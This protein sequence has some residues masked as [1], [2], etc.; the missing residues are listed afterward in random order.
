MKSLIQK[1]T[2]PFIMML[3]VTS[4]IFSSLNYAMA[5]NTGYDSRHPIFNNYLTDGKQEPVNLQRYRG[6]I[7]FL[8]F[9]AT[10]CQRCIK[11]IKIMDQ[12][13]ESAERKRIIFLPINIDFRGIKL[14]NK[15]YNAY[16]VK[17]L[18][19]VMDEFGKA[20]KYLN[21]SVLPTTVVIDESGVTRKRI[22]GQRTWNIDYVNSII[23]DVKKAQK[24][25]HARKIES[26]Q[27]E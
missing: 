10:W 20:V 18:R 25:E 22:I 7:V 19:P 27:T 17:K 21:V 15:A 11:Q 23:Q 6:N 4:I 3:I 9:W 2:N 12:L 1:F 24:L 8:I 16:G 13:Y 26:L 5:E 14:V